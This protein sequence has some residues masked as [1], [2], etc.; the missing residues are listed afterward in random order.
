MNKY[1]TLCASLLLVP[2]MVSGQVIVDD[3]FADNDR[4]ANGPLES[5][6]WTSTSSSAIEDG[7]DGLNGA[8]GLVTGGSGRGIHT[9][10]PSQN[11]SEGESITATMYFT[12]PATVKTGADGSAF[13]IM[14]LSPTDPAH[15]TALS[16]DLSASSG[17]PQPL[18][19]DLP[20]YMMDMDIGGGTEDL[21]FRR[22]DEPAGNASGARLGGTTSEWESIDSSGPDDGY[23]FDP[24]SDYY[25]VMT[26]SKTGTGVEV[27]G[28][29]YGP[30]GLLTSHTAEDD[31][32]FTGVTTDVGMFGVHANSGMFGSSSSAGDPDNGIDITR[33]TVEVVPEPATLGLLGISGA[34]ILALRRLRK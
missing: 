32:G 8:V 20:G 15:S 19:A 24:N 3:N 22:H 23:T 28:A 30:G 17:T 26:I 18:Y 2:L 13:K 9:I 16:A 1:T 34:F 11:L 25:T 29:L 33:F 21:N 7:S 10:F 6:W 27:S 4:A 5:S 14:F 12:T 31:S